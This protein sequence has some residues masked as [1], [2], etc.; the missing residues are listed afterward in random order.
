MC[1]FLLESEEKK[2]FAILR[3]QCSSSWEGNFRRSY[4]T[5]QNSPTFITLESQQL[6]VKGHQNAKLTRNPARE[7][8]YCNRK[9]SGDSRG[10]WMCLISAS[11]K[12]DFLFERWN[13]KLPVRPN[14]GWLFCKSAIYFQGNWKTEEW[15]GLWIYYVCTFTGRARGDWTQ[16][17]RADSS[18]PTSWFKLRLPH[19]LVA[20]LTPIT[21]SVSLT[22]LL[23]IMYQV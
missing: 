1:I 12:T 14:A 9:P 19:V 5:F 15:C 18:K 23:S 8:Q 17:P 21:S 16:N 6:I 10:P 11:T 4:P 22:T 2:A 20:W 13:C 3:R 7:T